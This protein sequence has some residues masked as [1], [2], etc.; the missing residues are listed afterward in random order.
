[1]LQS[2]RSSSGSW[3]AKGILGLLVISFLGWGIADYTHVGQH[4]TTVARVGDREINLMEFTNLYQNS[5]QSQNLRSLSPEVAQQLQ[6]A[7]SVLRSSIRRYL[8][9]QAAVDLGLTASDEMVRAA[10]QDRQEFRGLGGQ[11]DRGRFNFFLASLGV[12]EADFVELQRRELAAQGFIGTFI[13]GTAAPNGVS[14]LLFDYFGERRN[15]Q[16]ITLTPENA[17]IVM[18]QQI[19]S[20]S[21]LAAFYEARGE[22][23]RRPELRSLRYV[24]ITPEG[25]AEGI[26][27]A[28]DL[29]QEAY[30]QRRS[31][32]ERPE[33]RAI[34]QIVFSSQEDAEAAASALAGLEGDAISQQV[35]T[36]GL[37]LIELGEFA[38]DGIPNP[39]LAEAAFSLAGPGVTGAFEGAFGWSVAVVTAI[40]A[41]EDPSLEAVADQLRADLAL[42]EAYD[43][44]FALGSALEDAY[45]A[46]STLAQAG[47][48]VGLEV[49]LVD[50]V[51]QRGNGPDGQALTDLPAGLSFLRTAFDLDDGEVSFLE[52]TDANA[53]FM[54][55]VVSITPSA[56]PPLD[57]IRDLVLLAWQEEQLLLAVE[58][59]AESLVDRLSAGATLNEVAAEATLDIV[60]TTGFS[61]DGQV[62]SGDRVPSLL[63]QDLFAAATGDALLSVD[64]DSFHIAV[65]TGITQAGSGGEGDDTLRDTLE[66][67][68]SQGMGQDL[69]DQWGQALQ[70]TISVETFPQ[71]YN[72]VYLN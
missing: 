65:L 50:A 14:K 26:D 49:V 67:T 15:A 13:A 18:T 2:M 30:E 38:Q 48:Q 5:L 46:G 9:E 66:A 25:V 40:I 24:S 59:M 11:F 27:V 63:A 72:Q 6:L 70:N 7:D 12:A 17:P 52:T 47:E 3:I 43:E 58:E 64:G 16:Y 44:V 34:S 62:L 68:L 69:I 41:G 10:I 42:D 51:D 22:D 19:A 53:Q 57:Q 29:V 23:F 60:T 1:M 33:Q 37:S 61:R 32:F 56:I 35:E 31:E 39:A 71:V 54:V 55:E 28:E 20:D 36:L 4:D 45:G 21:E 8:Y